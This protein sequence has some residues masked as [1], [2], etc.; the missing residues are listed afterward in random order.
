[1]KCSAKHPTC[2]YCIY[3]K[4]PHPPGSWCYMFKRGNHVMR[5]DNTGWCAKYEGVCQGCGM[6]LTIVVDALCATCSGRLARTN[7]PNVK[8]CRPADSEAGAQKK[9]SNV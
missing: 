1:M 9:E 6:K 5:F 3:S 2:Q 7:S 8:L 4:M